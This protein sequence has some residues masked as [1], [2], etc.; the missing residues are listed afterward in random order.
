MGNKLG[1]RSFTK[2]IVK[3]LDRLSFNI[4][5]NSLSRN[6]YINIPL[7]EGIYEPYLSLSFIY[8]KKPLFPNYFCGGKSLFSIY[9]II[10]YVESTNYIS[11][12]FPDNSI[13]EFYSIDDNNLFYNSET[14]SRIETVKNDVGEII[15]YNYFLSDNSYF[16][17]KKDV[18]FPSELHTI[19][20]K[21]ITLDMINNHKIVAD[22][23]RIEFKIQGNLVSQ[24]N[25]Y[26]DGILTKQTTIEYIGNKISKIMKYFNNN[27]IKTYV[28][29]DND[30]YLLVKY[31]ENN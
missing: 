29:E 26:L 19:K 8:N 7:I 18:Y 12:I 31:L 9:K 11:V 24:L 22:N 3:N 17:Y 21:T 27:L 2:S 4:V 13:L 28:F 14:S 23:E 25:Y 10:T 30:A 20:G 16:Y 6:C 15:G 5:L 1:I